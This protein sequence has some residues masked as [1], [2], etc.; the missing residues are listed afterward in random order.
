MINEL[1]TSISNYLYSR[2]QITKKKA[3]VRWFKSIPELTALA[4]KVSRDITRKWHFENVNPKESGRNKVM[5]AN[6]F[7]Q[8]VVLSKTMFSQALDCLITGDGFGW[9]GSINDSM[10]KEAINKT[11]ESKYSHLEMK[12]RNDIVDSLF[13]ELKQE[14]GFANVSKVDEDLLRPRRYRYLPSSTVEVLHDVVDITGYRHTVGLSEKLF[15][16]EEVVHFTFADYDGKVNGFT[17]VESIIIQLELL[18][19]MWQNMLSIHLNGGSPDKLFILE[20]ARVGT[21][22]YRRIEEQLMKYKLV[23][24][25]HGNMVFTGKVSVE[26]LQQLD[27]MQFA[28]MGLYITGLMAMQWS[29]PRSS[30]PYIL[31]QA[32]TKTDVG[33]EAER[34]YWRNIEYVQKVFAD[35]MNTQLWMPYFGVQIVFDNAYIQFD[36]QEQTALMNKYQNQMTIS[37]ILMKHGKMLTLSKE[38]NTLGLSDDDIEDVPK[39]QMMPPAGAATGIGTPSQQSPNQV[40]RSSAQASRGDQKRD[41]QTKRSLSVGNPT[42]VGKEMDSNAEMEYKQIIGSEPMQLEIDAFMKLYLEDKAFNTTPPRVFMRKNDLYTTLI[43]KSTDFV[44]RSVVPNE[45]LSAVTLMNLEPNLY[46]L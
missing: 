17:P 29:V 36:V 10:V 5:R 19:Q 8:Q 11:I 7:A 39:E 35:T 34:E 25:K 23:E 42:G 1:T 18:R 41:E 44:Y 15:K 30:I 26:D 32:N 33:G 28:D 38:L 31:S 45:Q 9:M 46:L 3:L 20:D 12:E 40:N 13:R 37:N 14:N 22:S 43:Y 16:P 4:S 2:N 24:N 6:K 27:K 21:E